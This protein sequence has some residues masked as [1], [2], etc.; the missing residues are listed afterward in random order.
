MDLYLTEKDTGARLSFAHLPHEL[1][2]RNSGDFI[3][4]NFIK[5]GEAKIPGGLKLSTY[6]WTGTFFGHNLPF[7]KPHLYLPPKEMVTR[8]EQWRR[9]HTE[10]ILML[11][12]TPVNAD[13]Y[14]ESFDYTPTGGVGNIDYS[15]EFVEARSVTVNT[16]QE[17]ATT[18]SALSSNTASNT[19]PVTAV[20]DT[21][22]ASEQTRTYTVKSGDCLWNIAKQYLGKGSRYQEIYELNKSVIGANPNLIYPGQVYTLPAG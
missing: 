22:I 5:M 18:S 19:R 2:T 20:T 6:S 14:L 16:A 21:T 17:A 3:S 10:L 9:N 15:I 11:T 4:Y 8:I 7:A 13:V 1:K 12:E